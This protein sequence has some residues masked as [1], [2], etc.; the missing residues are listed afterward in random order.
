MLRGCNFWPSSL[1]SSTQSVIPPFPSLLPAYHHH[2]WLLWLQSECAF[3]ACHFYCSLHTQLHFSP[4]LGG[5]F[6]WLHIAHTET[7]AY[8]PSPCPSPTGPYLLSISPAPPSEALPPFG[9][10]H[11]SLNFSAICRL[12]PTTKE[13]FSP[14]PPCIPSPSGNHPASCVMCFLDPWHFFVASLVLTL[15][16]FFE[17]NPL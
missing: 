2:L 1:S 5:L 8:L 10:S 15:M 14:P 6:L 9:V 17:V 7:P 16:R 13:S 4:L 12:T 11:K 3:C